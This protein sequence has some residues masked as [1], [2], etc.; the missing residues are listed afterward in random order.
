MT[1]GGPADG[2]LPAQVRPGRPARGSEAPIE[3]IHPATAEEFR[4][5][6]QAALKLL[7]RR[8][9]AGIAEQGYRLHVVDSQAAHCLTLE[10]EEVCDPPLEEL[11]AEA[12]SL[13][14][15]ARQRGLVPGPQWL[16]R[17]LPANPELNVLRDHPAETPL[18]P[19]QVLQVPAC[20]GWQGRWISPAAWSFLTAPRL[21]NLAGMVVNGEQAGLRGRQLAIVLWDKVFRRGDGLTDWY[22]LHELGHTTDFSFAFRQP[23]PWRAWRGR[24]EA[25]F[26][27]ANFLTRYAGES[28]VEYFAE[29]FAAW[30]TPA[31]HRRAPRPGVEPEPL[32]RQRYEVDRS[33]LQERDP[34]LYS[35]IQEAVRLTL[36]SKDS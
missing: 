30:A 31:G 25:A 9:L 35:L 2:F 15:L 6:L 22:V 3:L 13:G 7:P 1:E 36:T 34:G 10:V 28:P 26:A 12:S 8:L 16:Q 21:N 19:G 14:E 4:P 24:L 11:Y 33:V 17:V 32:A 23:E 20:Y 27:Q 5:E 29:G 18:T